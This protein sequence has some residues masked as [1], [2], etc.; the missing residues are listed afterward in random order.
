MAIDPIMKRMNDL[1]AKI[2]HLE[3]RCERC[4][5]SRDQKGGGG[6]QNCLWQGRINSYMAELRDLFWNADYDED[7]VYY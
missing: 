3:K 1:R 5:G 4:T 2:E 7:S 6:C